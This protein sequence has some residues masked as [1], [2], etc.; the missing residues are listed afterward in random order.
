MRKM[1]ANDIIDI[2]SQILRQPEPDST[3]WLSTLDANP[4]P[5]AWSGLG[6]PGRDSIQPIDPRGSWRLAQKPSG[7]NRQITFPSHD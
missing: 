5:G 1:G 6:Q 7:R 4:K 2:R 3:S